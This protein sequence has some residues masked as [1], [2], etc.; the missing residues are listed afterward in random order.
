MFRYPGGKSK[1]KNLLI[2]CF[3]EKIK[4]YCEPFFGGGSVG[5]ELLKRNK[6]DNFWINDKDY[7]IYCIWY[8]IINHKEE[9]KELI[10]SLVPSVE[11]FNKFKYD[12][13]NLK[14][15]EVITAF[16][17]VVI[18]QLSYSGLGLKSGGPLGG[19]N[20]KS[21][22]KIDCRWSPKHIC[23]K[24]DNI[25]KLFCCNMFCTNEDFLNLDFKNYFV[26]CD[27]PYYIKG[28]QLYHCGSVDHVKIAD[29]L[30][31][32]NNWL[33]SYDDCQEIRSLYN[34]A[35]IKE[36]DIN[37]TINSSRNKKELIICPLK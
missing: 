23:N 35:K 3:P 25:S 8:A 24:I 2:S 32:C 17:K 33:L 21:I 27:P 36:L 16:K 37:Y 31:G 4:N 29:R 26:Y 22:Y 30:K 6:L 20:Q 7:G 5:L 14:E 10:N 18:H 34:W 12:L 13:L 9:F 1:I 19:K 28:E 15:I 11:C